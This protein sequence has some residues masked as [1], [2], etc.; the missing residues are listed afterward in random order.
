MENTWTRCENAIGVVEAVANTA[1]RSL[2]RD[3]RRVDNSVA[4]EGPGGTAGLVDCETEAGGFLVASVE[5][6]RGKDNQAA[7]KSLECRA[8]NPT[9][10][11]TILS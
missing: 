10:L 8:Q 4:A 1:S 2:R 9:Y 5:A 3:R 6:L 11:V 7:S